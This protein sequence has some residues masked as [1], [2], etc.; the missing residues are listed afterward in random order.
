MNMRI[1]WIIAFLST[2]YCFSQ[3][4]LG[5]LKVT[6]FKNDTDKLTDN[7]AVDTTHVRIINSQ[8]SLD[9]IVTFINSQNTKIN[10]KR[11]NYNLVLSYR[12]EEEIELTDILI[13]ADLISFVEVL[14]EPKM[15]LSRRE[16]RKRKKKYY[17]NY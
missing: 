4:A 15:A 10:L 14:I 5:V 13:S 1:L 17:A 6:T 2:N 3:V 9:T 7:Y 8:Y 12:N 11:G 16:I